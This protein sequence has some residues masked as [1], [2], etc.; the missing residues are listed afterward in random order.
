MQSKDPVQITVLGS[1][2]MSSLRWLAE[3]DPNFGKSYEIV[4]AFSDVPK[5]SGLEYAQGRDIPIEFLDFKKWCKRLGVKKKDL[6]AREAYFG[7]VLIELARWNA[8]AVLLSGFMLIVT[9]PVLSAYAGKILNVHPALLSILDEEGERKYTG[10][11]VVKRA[12][13][14]GDPTGST[15]HIVTEKADM[16]PIVAESEPLPYEPGTDPADHQDRMKTVCD[17]P[18]YQ[19]ALEKLIG[20]GWP[21]EAWQG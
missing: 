12:M 18:A 21:E 2:S 11:N 19:M 1:G 13:K 9:N 17:G 14:N 10:F 8:D 4:G 7:H 5:S 6:W 3:N 15:V 16:G 20:A